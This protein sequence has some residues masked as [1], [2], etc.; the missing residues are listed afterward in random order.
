MVTRRTGATRADPSHCRHSPNAVLMLCHHSIIVWCWASVV[1]SGPASNQYWLHYR[2][3]HYIYAP[4]VGKLLGQ[5]RRRWANIVPTLDECLTFVG[6][7]FGSSFGLVVNPCH[8]GTGLV[9]RLGRMIFFHRIAKWNTQ[10]LKCIA[11]AL[12]L[13]LL[14]PRSISDEQRYSK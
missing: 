12:N 2:S 4:N 6:S 14:C 8:G 9:S 1:Y 11:K 5:R 3:K 13:S 10:R 7:S